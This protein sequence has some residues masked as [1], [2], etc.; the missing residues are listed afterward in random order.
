MKQIRVIYDS[1]NGLVWVKG[2]SSIAKGNNVGFFGKDAKRFKTDRAAVRYALAL[3]KSRKDNGVFDKFLGKKI[4]IAVLSKRLI[5]K[6]RG[7]K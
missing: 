5:N 3:A 2:Q 6:S 4:S 1:L 7:F